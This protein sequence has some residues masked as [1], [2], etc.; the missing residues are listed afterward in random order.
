MVKSSF[1]GGGGGL[2]R[3]GRAVAPG[4]EEVPLP[5]PQEDNA[6]EASINSLL[7]AF[8][9]PNNIMRD[10]S[11]WEVYYI[12]AA[13]PV[14][15]IRGLCVLSQT[16]VQVG[17]RHPFSRYPAPGGGSRGVLKKKKRLT[18]RCDDN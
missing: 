6:A 3:H 16:E 18:Y 4:F 5:S 17:R 7:L 10:A 8:P 9:E 15:N 13:L 11:G 2:A 12:F 1:S 14:G